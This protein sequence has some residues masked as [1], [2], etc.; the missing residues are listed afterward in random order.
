MSHYYS[1]YPLLLLYWLFCYDASCIKRSISANN[2]SVSNNDSIA[3][4]DPI[5]VIPFTK[6][7][8][9]W[10][11]LIGIDP[12]EH[13]IRGIPFDRVNIRISSYPKSYDNN[14]MTI[15]AVRTPSGPL[16]ADIDIAVSLRMLKY[17]MTKGVKSTKD[18][19][20]KIKQPMASSCLNAVHRAWHSLKTA[21]S[22]YAHLMDLFELL[23]WSQLSEW[24]IID[25]L[26]VKIE[27]DLSVREQTCMLD[28]IARRR[29]KLL[30][31]SKTTS[32]TSGM[33]KVRQMYV[34]SYGSL[35]MTVV[36]CSWFKPIGRQERSHSYRAS[37]DDKPSSDDRTS[38]HGARSHAVKRD[39]KSW[40][41]EVFRSHAVFGN[42]AGGDDRAV[43]S[44]HHQL[45]SKDSTAVKVLHICLQ[46]SFSNIEA[47]SML[48]SSMDGIKSLHLDLRINQAIV[49][50]QQK[51]SQSLCQ[52]L[53]NAM[54][55]MT[56][57]PTT[58]ELSR[59]VMHCLI[60]HNDS[61][62]VI[63]PDNVKDNRKEQQS[64]GNPIADTEGNRNHRHTKIYG[65]SKHAELGSQ[66]QI[67][68][69]SPD[70]LTSEARDSSP[71]QIPYFFASI[72]QLI[73]PLSHSW[74]DTVQLLALFPSLSQLQIKL[75]RNQMNH[76]MDGNTTLLK[77]RQDSLHTRKPSRKKYEQVIS[78][79]IAWSS[80]NNI[81]LSWNI[82]YQS[83][84]AG[85]CIHANPFCLSSL[86][87]YHDFCYYT[88]FGYAQISS[89]CLYHQ[90]NFALWKGPLEKAIQAEANMLATFLSFSKQ[91]NE[92][93]QAEE[94]LTIELGKNH[95]Q[96]TESKELRSIQESSDSQSLQLGQPVS[97]VLD[98]SQHSVI[99][100]R[101]MTDFIL[102]L[103]QAIPQLKDISMIISPSSHGQ[104][105]RPIE[106]EILDSDDQLPDILH[107]IQ[108]KK[109]QSTDNE[110][111]QY[112]LHQRNV[113]LDEESLVFWLSM[114]RYKQSSSFTFKLAYRCDWDDTVNWMDSPQ[115][116]MSKRTALLLKAL[117]SYPKANAQ[118]KHPEEQ[119]SMSNREGT[120]RKEYHQEIAE[121]AIGSVGFPQVWAPFMRRLKSGIPF[122]KDKK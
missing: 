47:L 87:S 45:S 106:K 32:S 30:L 2:T 91:T 9:Y 59:D 92:T 43:L 23:R 120:W 65:N 22:K 38:S 55:A 8:Q 50:Q 25:I 104:Y 105:L 20:E 72:K 88:P 108:Q 122:S 31:L 103:K 46:L 40:S 3:S 80:K 113:N 54:A 24:L 76:S 56:F 78:S 15:H 101:G 11:D 121:F 29:S 85:L 33:T 51:N 110:Q 4:D 66:E 63:D 98:V 60:S 82:K 5:T 67:A 115:E 73:I 77:H 69:V 42:Y 111:S 57:R 116:L 36:L 102:A 71:L 95:M 19:A 10:L 70:R 68:S 58:L 107:S 7:H 96:Q 75:T 74:T 86:S 18:E 14:Q 39:D 81:T 17:S 100:N 27:A 13:T 16:L 97:I 34:K 49:Q 83:M 61:S 12:V 79:I 64:S 26:S 53:I 117:S 109:H 28:G 118:R 21:S 52:R 99:L 35:S 62:Q 6:G 1:L 114:F 41:Q 44:S 112:E 93:E 37:K 89:A 119:K 84:H 48:M 90:N 94:A